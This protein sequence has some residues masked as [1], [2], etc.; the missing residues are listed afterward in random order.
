M[1]KTYEYLSGKLK[2]ANK[3]I[4]PDLAYK[5]WSVVLYPDQAS[6]N[7][8]MLL[9]EP[10]AILNEIKKDEEGYYITLSR[11]TSRTY[12]GVERAFVP[13]L[14]TNA[15]GTACTVPIG[16]GS[17]GT[18]KIEVYNYKQK[19]TGKLGRAIR[20]EAVRV[21]NLIPYTPNKDRTPEQQKLAQGLDEQ[22]API[23]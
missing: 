15:D 17:D 8:I 20:L 2:W 13:P 1:A 10:P 12:Q 4:Q 5:K 16:N 23:F 6:Y 14:V 22:P 7:K 9:K 11:P 19:V 21:D 18:C 3:L